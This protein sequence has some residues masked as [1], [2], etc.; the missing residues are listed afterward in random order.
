VTVAV[1]GGVGRPTAS[2]GSGAAAVAGRTVVDD[3]VMDERLIR[4]E[5]YCG[6]RVLC[7][8]RGVGE[9]ACAASGSTPQCFHGAPSESV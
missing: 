8:G 3:S 4:W 9:S 6:R 7:Q 1:G 2:V 5:F